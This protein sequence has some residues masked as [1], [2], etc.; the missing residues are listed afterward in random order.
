MPWLGRTGVRRARRR[1]RRSRRYRTSQTTMKV[2]YLTPPDPALRRLIEATPS[3]M[4]YWSGTGPP[5][6]VCGRCCF[7]G[8]QHPNSCYRVYM[9]ALQHGAAFPAET[10]SCKYFA[11]QWPG[12]NEILRR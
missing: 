2:T 9:R 5:G 10:P 4:A 11:P 6:T 7:Y 12:S 3:G 1:S 8:M